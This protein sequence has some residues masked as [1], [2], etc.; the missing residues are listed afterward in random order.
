LPEATIQDLDEDVQRDFLTAYFADTGENLFETLRDSHRDL[1]DIG[2]NPY[3]LL[4]IGQVYQLQGELPPNRGLLFQ[5]FVNALLERE[6]KTHPDRWL[7]AEI[8]LRVLSDLA[9][10]IQ[11]E[12]GRGTSVPREW[13]GKY[14]T[15]GVRVNGRDIA[16]N[17]A[18]LL[19]L[20]RSASLL[21]ESTDGSLRF[22]HQLLQEYF[23]AVAL[24]RFGVN[25]PQVREAARYCS[26]DEVLVLLAG[27]MEDAT[28]P[29]EVVMAVDPYSAARCVGG[30]QSIL[31]DVNQVLIGQLIGK[32]S[33][34]FKN[35]RVTA[36]TMLGAIKADAAIPYL[37][38]LLDHREEYEVRREAIRAL[39]NLRAEAAIPN[40]ILLLDDM[41]FLCKNHTDRE[42]YAV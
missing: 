31:P 39:G 6:R 37:I 22:T 11:R 24:L 8:Q 28:P 7:D 9:F 26:W 15:G 5:S 3:M 13:A 1:L 21:D 36:V 16:Y 33:S 23:A 14:L 17:S 29:V 10:A 40:L 4:M 42:D 18:D 25:D 30:V 38:L 20:A 12:H 35:E 2:R 32:L 41:V 19:Y 34:R 27:L